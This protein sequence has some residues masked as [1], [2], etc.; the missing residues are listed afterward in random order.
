MMQSA[1][2][3]SLAAH[4]LA[5]LVA[6]VWWSWPLPHP[7]EAEARFEVMFGTNADATGAP[8][9]TASPSSPPL[10]SAADAL[11]PA[12]SAAATATPTAPVQPPGNGKVGLIVQHADANMVEAQSDPGNRAPKFPESSWLAGEEGTVL[13]RLHIDPQ[14][15]VARAELLQS[16]GYAALDQAATAALSL[17]HFIPALRDGVAVPSYRD[18]AT[19]FRMQEPD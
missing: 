19:N 3:V 11:L 12:A 16:S 2:V 13:L 6:L 14:G 8:A 15:H 7:H 18:Q 9:A 10:A 5:V 4:V 1:A 17:W